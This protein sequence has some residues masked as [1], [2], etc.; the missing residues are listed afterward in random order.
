MWHEA[1]VILWISAGGSK[2]QTALTEQASTPGEDTTVHAC[3][4]VTCVCADA[5]ARG[6]IYVCVCVCEHACFCTA[7]SAHSNIFQA[8]FVHLSVSSSLNYRFACSQCLTRHHEISG[9]FNACTLDADNLLSSEKKMKYAALSVMVSMSLHMHVFIPAHEAFPA[10]IS[11]IERRDRD[12]IEW[13]GWKVN[14]Q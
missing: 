10:H 3:I 9:K 6:C 2:F 1:G 13:D 12:E 5:S 11:F 8:A 14:G 7:C 4:S